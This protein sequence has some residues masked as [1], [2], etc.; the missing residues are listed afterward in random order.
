MYMFSPLAAD[1]TTHVIAHF[2][3]VMHPYEWPS[4]LGNCLYRITYS[5][6]VAK[7]SYRSLFAL[8]FNTRIVVEE[9]EIHN[10]SIWKR[11]A[12]LVMVR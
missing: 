5:R 6:L 1:C 8:S 3:R 12:Q 7:Q 11:H 4:L 2:Y 9:E 10:A